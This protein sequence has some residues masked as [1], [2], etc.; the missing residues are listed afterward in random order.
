VNFEQAFDRLIGH[1]GGYANYPSDP[2]GETMWGV[3]KNVA[4]ANG[5]DG[6]MRDL[7]RETAK[8][9][10]RK[11]YWDAIK[12]DQLPEALRF[13]V[14]DAAVN[15]G[16]KQA[17]KWLQRVVGVVDDGALG[18]MTLAAAA[19]LNGDRAAAMYSG[20]RLEFMT[21]LPTWGMFGRGW[22]KRIAS[23]LQGA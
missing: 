13:H 22:S 17:V 4:R 16:V 2:G 15:S 7:P 8:A 14:F 1:E 18:P 10:Y 11:Q 6:S 23:N 5:Y 9:I 19:N 3:T 20:V 21:G 12:A